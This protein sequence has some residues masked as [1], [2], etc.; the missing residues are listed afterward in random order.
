MLS[1]WIWSSSSQDCQWNSYWLAQIHNNFTITPCSIHT[2]PRQCVAGGAL[3]PFTVRLSLLPLSLFLV[4]ICVTLRY[5][6][7]LSQTF[8]TFIRGA[9]LWCVGGTTC[10]M[11]S[12]QPKFVCPDAVYLLS[13]RS[14]RGCG[15]CCPP[16][17]TPSTITE[18]TLTSVTKKLH[19]FF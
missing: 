2:N 14:G 13:K 6:G 10:N 18:G 1:T 9:T 3:A 12:Y 8:C 7:I 4:P 5:A 11:K 15:N 16:V 19:T 17:A